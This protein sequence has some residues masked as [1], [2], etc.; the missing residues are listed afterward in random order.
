MTY[1]K[2]TLKRKIHIF[3]NKEI[4]NLVIAGFNALA[5]SYGGRKVI[6][7]NRLPRDWDKMSVE[8]KRALVENMT[9]ETALSRDIIDEDVLRELLLDEGFDESTLPRVF[10]DPN[11]PEV[12]DVI[13]SE[14]EEIAENESENVGELYI[15]HQDLQG[16]GRIPK[17]EIEGMVQDV[18][19][20][21]VGK[22]LIVAI[23]K[24]KNGFIVTGESGTLDP[25]SFDRATG[26][27]I[28]YRR[29][30]DKLWQLEGYRRV[31]STHESKIKV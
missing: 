14:E 27:G 26:E 16:T 24:L 17:E 23:V 7:Y 5:M 8:G 1:T 2:D 25:T 3:E 6:E 22:Q 12:L 15:P 10:S 30:L 21:V 20:V 28:A 13:Q 31:A 9:L 4:A 19:Y 18:S 11:Q 29:A